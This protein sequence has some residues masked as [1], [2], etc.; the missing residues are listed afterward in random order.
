MRMG[1]KILMMLIMMMMMI[2]FLGMLSHWRY[3]QTLIIIF[4]SLKVIFS[5]ISRLNFMWHFYILRIYTVAGKCN[6]VGKKHQKVFSF[7]SSISYFLFP[8]FYF[9]LSTFDESRELEELMVTIMMQTCS[10][11]EKTKTHTCF[12]G[13]FCTL[14]RH[15]QQHVAML[16]LF[17]VHQSWGKQDH[18][19]VN[20]STGSNNHLRSIGILRSMT[21]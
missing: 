8:T 14:W 4:F 5:G 13:S 20:N 2:L 18:Q 19:R 11:D 12:S 16:R 7:S 9:L 15:P 10:V 3:T 1:V 21:I 6:V 17:V